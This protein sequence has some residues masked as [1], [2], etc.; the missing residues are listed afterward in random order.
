MKDRTHQTAG[1]VICDF[2]SPSSFDTRLSERASA[3]VHPW[4]LWI[5]LKKFWTFERAKTDLHIQAVTKLISILSVPVTNEGGRMRNNNMAFSLTTTMT[6]Y[7]MS[8]L[9]QT[10]H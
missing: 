5:F 3:N 1:Q 2:R 8:N 10:C 6:T 9:A 4:L 7:N